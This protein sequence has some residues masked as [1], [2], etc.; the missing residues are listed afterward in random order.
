[1]MFKGKSDWDQIKIMKEKSKIPIIGNGDIFKAEDAIRMMDETGCDGVMIA[2][3]LIENPF[4]AEEVIAAF[5]NEPYDTAS[6]EKKIN[7]FCQPRAA[8]VKIFR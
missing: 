4:L 8:Y 2:R 7:T 1:M 6:M 3:G 5:K